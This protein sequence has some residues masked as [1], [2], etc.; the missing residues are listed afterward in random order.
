M[1]VMRLNLTGFT[2]LMLA[3]ATT[4]PSRATA[5]DSA[6]SSAETAPAP[7]STQAF[8]GHPAYAQVQTL[9]AAR[10]PAAAFELLMPLEAEFGGD[11]DYDYYFG[12]ASLDSGHA[13]LAVFALLRVLAG[14]PDFAGA[15][16]ELAR[17]YFDAGDYEDAR[18]EFAILAAQNPPAGA[19]AAIAEYLSAI[20][21]RSEAGRNALR[22]SLVLFAGQDSNA[23]AGTDTER[24]V[25]IPLDSNSRTTGSPYFGAE[26]RAAY[27]RPLNPDWRWQGN[28]LLR[29][30]EYPEAS[31]VSSSVGQVSAGL[32]Y[33]TVRRFAAFDVSGRWTML[34]GQMNQQTTA[35][36][37]TG[38]FPLGGQLS[39]AGSL[40][41]ALVR[42]QDSVEVQDVDQ[43]LAGVAL[44]WRAK[45]T[46]SRL[47]LSAGPVFG[48]EEAQ[49]RGSPYGR[50]LV[51]GRAALSMLSSG[52]LFRGSLG[53]LQSDYDGR[54]FG[55]SRKDEQF[56]AQMDLELPR[57]FGAWQ[58]RPSLAYV[59]NRSDLSLFEYDRLEAGIAM[60]RSF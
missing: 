59:R 42:Y 34:E 57:S 22:S 21:R 55:E 50:D 47:E 28:A 26:A 27:A 36:D 12:L 60:I 56:T 14:N 1:R 48:H 16:L 2:V 54:F 53:L 51:G 45:D 13:S 6:P 33:G 38:E 8:S 17:A 15:R 41:A 19:S 35:A 7:A 40:R 43:S 31:F 11:P 4:A 52:L 46:L 9:L 49:E 32:A 23:N 18:R 29:H 37:L 39:V 24:F 3:V 25:G 44:R 20:D 58:L 10:D 5:Q 30:R